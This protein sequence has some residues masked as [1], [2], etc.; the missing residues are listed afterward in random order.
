MEQRTLT[1]LRVSH[2]RG[3]LQKSS[4][5]RVLGRPEN[6]TKNWSERDQ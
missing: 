2:P 6:R 4:L 3:N 1:T 5:R